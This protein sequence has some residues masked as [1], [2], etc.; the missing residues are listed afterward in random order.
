LAPLLRDALS[1]PQNHPVFVPSKTY[2]AG[3]RNVTIHLM[4]GYAFIASDGADI[5][6]PSRSDQP[7]VKRMLTTPTP[8]GSRVLSVVSDKVV[9]EM[10]ANLSKH[11]G[12]DVRVGSRVSVT[13]G[14][15]SKMEGEVVDCATSG[16]L[17]VRFRLRSLDTIVEVPRSFT[18]P[19]DGAD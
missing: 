5:L 11:V 18:V 12:D 6:F 16:N 3:G 19:C 14:L 9:L 7:Y 8:N 1:L 4:E 13:T 15:Y 2:T 17:V 10:E